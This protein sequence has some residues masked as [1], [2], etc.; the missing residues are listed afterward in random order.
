MLI[1]ASAIVAMLTRVPEA[2]ALA[3]AL[4]QATWP[5]TA[6]RDL[7]GGAEICRERHVSVVE[8]ADD[9]REFLDVAEAPS[10]RQLR[11]APSSPS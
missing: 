1:D 3:D 9:V 7:R 5:I 6:D 4:E 11:C 8:S 10:R 2:D